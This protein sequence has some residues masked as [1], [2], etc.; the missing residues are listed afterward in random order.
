MPF[1]DV[2]QLQVGLYVF[3]DLG[4]TEHP[5][6]LNR[7]KI[8]SE[9]QLT[10]IRQLG[11]RRIKY[12]PEKSDVEPLPLIVTTAQNDGPENEGFK[13]EDPRILAKRL[14]QEML[15]AQQASMALC[16]Q[17]FARAS[18]VVKKLQLHA[19]SAPSECAE[20]ATQLIRSFVKEITATEEVAIRLLS[21]KNGEEVAAHALNVAILSSLLANAMGLSPEQLMA[22]GLGA[23]LHDIGKSELPMRVRYRDDLKAPLDI[24]QYYRHVD[25]GMT[26]VQ[27]MGLSQEVLSVVAQHH[28]F[29]DGSGY[30]QG[31]GAE[32]IS[33]S[34]RIVAIVNQY[35]NYCNAAN[36]LKAITPH[37]ALSLMYAKQRR[38]F[39]TDI[40]T[41]FVRMMGVYPP[42]SVVQ[43][44]DE[45]YAMV[46]TVN[47]SRPLKPQVVI[48]EEAVPCDNAIVVNLEEIEELSVQRSLKPTQLPRAVF[49][50]LSPRTRMCYFFERARLPK[51][52]TSCS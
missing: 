15:Q 17:Q 4:W 42:G 50:Y 8:K 12:I 11:L 48:Y 25:E 1:I 22:V 6:P 33:L 29:G 26:L 37:E 19:R 36:P 9:E 44:S 23:L 20:S 49:D 47:M 28:A 3:L 30:P 32:D 40:M 18:H 41:Q 46:T 2:S 35:D 51:S 5:F 38:Q 16:E 21:E 43:L 13:E 10:Q 14:R 34:A 45:R 52:D 7:F 24:A 39:D 27:R 31:M